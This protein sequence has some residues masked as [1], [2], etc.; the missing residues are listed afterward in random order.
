MK[1]SD[2][3]T[4]EIDGA[5]VVAVAARET[6][7]DMGGLAYALTIAERKRGGF[8]VTR[9]DTVFSVMSHILSPIGWE[10]ETGGMRFDCAT[11]GEARSHISEWVADFEKKFTVELRA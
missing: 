3:A 11:E 8:G 6:A 9:N 10:F 7:S 1:V 4:Q 2:I 5:K